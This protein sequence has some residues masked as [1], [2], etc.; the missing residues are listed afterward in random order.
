MT[1]GWGL[2]SVNSAT[3]LDVATARES[4]RMRATQSIHAKFAVWLV[5]AA[6][7]FSLYDVVPW[8]NLLWWALPFMAMAEVNWHVSNRVVVALPDA[9]PRELR[10]RQLQLWW[11]SALNQMLCGSTVW[12]LGTGGQPGLA[13]LATGLQL[14]YVAAALV[15]AATHPVSFVT[16]AWINLA[17]ACVFWLTRDTGNVPLVLALVGTGVMLAKLSLQM[18]HNLRESLRMRFDNDDLLAQLAAEKRVAEEATQFKSDFLANISHEVR[19]PVSA[20]MG[21]SYLALKSDLTD[22]QRDYLQVIQQCSLH[23]QGLISQVLDFSKMEASMLVLERAEFNLRAVIDSVQAINA[24]KAAVKGLSLRVSV[25]A[26]TPP[27]LVGDALRLTEIL[28][29][30]ISN[31]IKFTDEGR[32]Q[33]DIELVDQQPGRVQLRFTVQDSGI[34]LT[35]EQLTR[36]FKS[37]SQGEVGTARKYGGTGLGL[38]ISK[39]LAELMGGDVGVSSEQGMGSSFWCTAWFDLPAAPGADLMD[40]G[41]FMASALARPEKWAATEPTR[42]GGARHGWPPAPKMAVPKP[43]CAVNW[44]RWLHKTTRPRWRC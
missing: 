22:K 41:S 16:G 29:N 3:S 32:V 25:A 42:Q 2:L 36:L 15:N 17:S 7:V 34:G 5:C 39:K 12:W 18:A 24:D 8:A 26:N 38:V 43:A 9:S 31:A 28:V 21:M 35:P 44:L 23:L 14:V 19:T 27:R 33:L 20:I 10:Q 1:H 30:F 4:L 13:E 6:T 11:M 40:T 37:F